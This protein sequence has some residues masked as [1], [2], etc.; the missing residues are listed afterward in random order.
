MDNFV[1]EFATTKMSRLCT[2]ISE[3]A[4]KEAQ[5]MLFASL[6]FQK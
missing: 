4:K 2:K 6:V 1:S 5:F 3:V